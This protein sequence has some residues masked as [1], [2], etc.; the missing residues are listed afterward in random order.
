MKNLI[1]SIMRIGT[2]TMYIRDKLN[3]TSTFN[4]E[5][6]QPSACHFPSNLLLAFLLPAVVLHHRNSVI[7]LINPPLRFSHNYN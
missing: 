6:T 3:S 2:H 7:V 1:G 4:L 5:L